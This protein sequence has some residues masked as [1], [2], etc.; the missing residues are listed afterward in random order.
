MFVDLKNLG[1]RSIWALSFP[2]S[3]GSNSP[4]NNTRPFFNT[5][6]H[7]GPMYGPSGSAQLVRYLGLTFSWAI[8]AKFW[9]RRFGDAWESCS[10]KKGV[11]VAIF[12]LVWNLSSV[13]AR[14][15]A[16]N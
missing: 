4:R 7:I 12:V 10:H 1:S 16:G 8:A 3:F 9:V 13:V 14:I 15:W 6:N 11:A 2:G 5:L